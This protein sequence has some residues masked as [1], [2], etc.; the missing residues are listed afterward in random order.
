MEVKT[1]WKL[2]MLLFL[3]I[4]ES[5][6]RMWAVTLFR[7]D[8][9]KQRKIND[10]PQSNQYLGTENMLTNLGTSLKSYTLQLSNHLSPSG[11][12]N[13]KWVNQY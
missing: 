12:N 13:K 1:G 6:L 4:K 8:C 7:M 3:L 9:F 2:K 5:T 11:Q 10:S